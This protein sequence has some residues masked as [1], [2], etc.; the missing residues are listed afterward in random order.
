M[1]FCDVTVDGKRRVGQGV[2]CSTC[3]FLTVSIPSI[4]TATCD[5]GSEGDL[6]AFANHITRSEGQLDR[7]KC[8]N[9]D[10]IITHSLTLRGG[11]IDMD[12]I[13]GRGI[14]THREGA[15]GGTNDRSFGRTVSGEPSVGQ[16]F[17]VIVAQISCKD[18]IATCANGIIGSSNFN[19]DV[20]VHIDSIR[21]ADTSTTVRVE[22]FNR[23]DV[24]LVGSWVVNCNRGIR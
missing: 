2:Q 13:I 19:Y 9:R 15:A 11:L 12:L 17:S 7:V 4:G 23:V 22:Y 18:N 5:V 14:R 10:R 8:D 24:R 6:T 16:V 21:F 3:N 1:V 20:T